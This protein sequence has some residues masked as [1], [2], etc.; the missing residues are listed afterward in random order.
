MAKLVH[1]AKL[2]CLIGPVA[3]HV[4]GCQLGPYLPAAAGATALYCLQRS[5]IIR[6]TP[7]QHN[8]L[9]IVE[10]QYN[11]QNTKRPKEDIMLQRNF[12][13][14]RNVS[15]WNSLP[16]ET[17]DFSGLDKFNNFVSNMFLLKFCQVNFE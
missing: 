16:A 17:T 5:C 6:T 13:S 11:E 10:I 3:A 4:V 9:F 8:L 12:F 14:I 7:I 1:S 15:M 2:N